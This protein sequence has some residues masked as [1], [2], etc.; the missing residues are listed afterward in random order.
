MMGNAQGAVGQ[1]PT[2][3]DNL[4][5]GIVVADIVPYL[6]EATES[7][8]VSDRIGKHNLSTKCH[9]SSDAC[10]VLFGDARIDETPRKSLHKG[11]DY[12]EAEI[13][14]DQ[15]NSAILLC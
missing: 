3:A 8:E 15:V 1:P 10:H 12:A 11:L 14:D 13:S 5:V 7:W 4:Y 2:D 9:S 6:L